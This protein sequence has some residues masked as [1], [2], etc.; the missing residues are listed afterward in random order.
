MADNTKKSNRPTNDFNA[1]GEVVAVYSKKG[2]STQSYLLSFWTRAL[3]KNSEVFIVRT[4]LLVITKDEDIPEKGDVVSVTGTINNYN[5]KTSVLETTREILRR[6]AVQEKSR[7][8]KPA[9]QPV[10]VEEIEDDDDFGD[11]I[12][13]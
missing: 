4:S 2:W 12:P 1:T 13:F 11:E 9:K 6:S 8:R 5:G 10:V 7:G 3:G